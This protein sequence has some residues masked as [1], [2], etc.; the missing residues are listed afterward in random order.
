ME[1]LSIWLICPWDLYIISHG[2]SYAS[3]GRKGNYAPMTKTY[4]ITEAIYY[5]HV[6]PKTFQKWLTK[7]NIDLSGQISR[8]DNRVRYLTSEQLTQLAHAIGRS[9]SHDTVVS[10]LPEEALRKW[11]PFALRVCQK[12]LSPGM[13]R[14]ATM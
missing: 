6:D 12:V 1:M 9:G 13:R 3:T 5:L 14:P 2:S 7:A 11:S 4:T 10:W 8:A